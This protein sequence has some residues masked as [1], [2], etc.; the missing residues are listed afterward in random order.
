MKLLTKT[1]LNF[2]SISLFIF[3]FGIFAFY[4][5]MRQQIDENVNSELAK[6]KNSILHRFDSL[7]TSGKI[8]GRYDEKVII[9]PYGGSANDVKYSDTLI[10]DPFNMKNTVFRQL[11]FFTIHKG[12]NYQIRI[13]KSLDETD[14]L[15]VRI[16]IIMTALVFLIIILLLIMNRRASLKAWNVFYDTID[17]IKRYNLNSQ[18]QFQLKQSDVKEFDELNKVLLAMINKIQTDYVNLKEYTENASHEIQTPLAIINAKMELLL[19]SGDLKENQLRAV[20]DAYEATNRLSKLNNTLI[21]L[22]KIENGQFPESKQMDTEN[23]IDFQLGN[24]EDLILSKKI[25]VIRN[26]KEPASVHMNPYLAEILF[27]NLVKNAIRHNREGGSM[28]IDYLK[29]QVEISNTGS[30]HKIDAETLFNR[31]QKSSSSAESLGLGLSIVKKICEVYGFK[32][33]YV[34][35]NDMHCIKVDFKKNPETFS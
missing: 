3:L 12:Q 11:S 25:N 31:F 18:E 4:Y 16:F 29:D 9:I 13:F 7:Q 34:Y 8:L 1:N 35:K 15:I 21:L 17:K 22:A 14:N 5:L 23:L 10:Y 20:S 33:D 26:T 24:L 32:L 19:Q 28:V 27:S 6:K 2:L 30:K